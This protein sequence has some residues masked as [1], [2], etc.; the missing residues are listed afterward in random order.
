M[1]VSTRPVSPGGDVVQEAQKRLRAVSYISFRDLR[2]E[3][4]HGLLILQGWVESY[5]ERQLAQE[6]VAGLEG[7]SQVV[8]QIEVNWV[9][10]TPSGD[11]RDEP[12]NP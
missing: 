2:C 3:Y 5:Y 10:P 1:A 11:Q 9:I 12:L 8:N 7:V 4:Q 6:V